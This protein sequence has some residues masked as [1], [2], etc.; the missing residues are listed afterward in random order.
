MVGGHGDAHVKVTEFEREL[1]AADKFLVVPGLV[2]RIGHH[3]G[4]PLSHQEDVVTVLWKMFEAIAITVSCFAVHQGITP[5]DP[6]AQGLTWRQRPGQVDPHQGPIDGMRQRAAIVILDC[7]YFETAIKLIDKLHI[8]QLGISNA[9][10][11]RHGFGQR[12][13][14]AGVEF[15]LVQLEPHIA[16]R[17]G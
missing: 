8:S 5:V 3:P 16:Q 10:R 9:I 13:H 1:A 6:E 17:V 11:F 14:G 2:V 4:V 12:I 15:V 7:R